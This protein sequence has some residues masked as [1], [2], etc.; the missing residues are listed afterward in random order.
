MMSSA[1]SAAMQTLAKHQ[2]AYLGQRLDLDQALGAVTQALFLTAAEQRLSDVSSKERLLGL[3]TAVLTV[4]A[5]HPQLFLG[6]GQTAGD[7]LN[8]KLFAEV[9]TLLQRSPPP[10]D[11]EAGIALASLALD[12]AAAQAARL[13]QR[14][15][16]WR[17][18]GLQTLGL[19]TKGLSDSLQANAKLRAALSGVQLTEIGRLLLTRVADTPV[20]ALGADNPALEGLLEAVT[21]AMI[22]DQNLLLSGDDW[23]Q[24]VGVAAEEAATNPARLFALDPND[25]SKVLA[26]ELMRVVLSGASETLQSQSLGSAAVLY[27]KTL[28]EAIIILLHAGAG[29][30]QAV[31]ANVVKIKAL[32]EKLNELVA[33][34]AQRL[35][36]KEWLRLFRILLPAAL[37]GRDLPALDLGRVEEL[38]K[39][40][41]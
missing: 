38:L 41:L 24:I 21:R 7:E 20:M 11:R 17:R 39:G 35:G 13:G 26:G 14:N 37:E 27:G 32:I 16:Q 9:L 12:A 25:R 22:A 33:V 36:S 23:L 31:R 28:R 6:D 29:N 19:L 34:N 2:G 30:P 5:Q 3:Y 10:F 4:A 40:V 15:D 1:A 18:A 8:R